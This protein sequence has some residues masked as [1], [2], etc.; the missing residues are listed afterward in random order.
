MIISSKELNAKLCRQANCRPIAK[1]THVLSC[2]RRAVTREYTPSVSPTTLNGW[3]ARAAHSA[4]VGVTWARVL[5]STRH[6]SILTGSQ[7]VTQ[8]GRADPP[9]YAHRV[10]TAQ[11]QAAHCTHRQRSFGDGQFNIGSLTQALIFN[12]SEY[13]NIISNRGTTMSAGCGGL[14]QLIA[15]PSCMYVN[16]TEMGRRLSLHYDLC[17]KIR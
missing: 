17:S 9:S 5:P 13:F 10:D 15:E 12:L 3:L 2:T 14:V 1:A 7:Y 8:C 4:S 16:S 11:R 6:S